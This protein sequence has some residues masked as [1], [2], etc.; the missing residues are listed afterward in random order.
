MF[1]DVEE[2]Q[3]HLPQHA[4]PSLPMCSV[5]GHVAKSRDQ[6][7]THHQKLHVDKLMMKRPLACP[8]CAMRFSRQAKRAEHVMNQHNTEWLDVAEVC[9]LF[10]CC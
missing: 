1:A 3:G 6:M 9:R 7:L 8:F 10:F 2:L 5:C 4:H